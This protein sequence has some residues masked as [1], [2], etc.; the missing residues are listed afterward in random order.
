MIIN[1]LKKVSFIGFY[2]S[3][4]ILFSCQGNT[5]KPHDITFTDDLGREI[6]IQSH[7]P[8]RFMAISPSLTEMLYLIGHDSEIVGRTQNCNY[9]PEVLKKPVIH[10]YPMDYEGLISL[11]PDLVFAKEGIISLEQAAKIEEMGIPVFFQQYYKS[12]D[13]FEGIE[14]LGKVLGREMKARMISDSLR[15]RK[16]DLESVNVNLHRPRVL[17]IISSDK[18][19]A[20]GKNSFASDIL[21]LAG[22]INAIDT[23]LNN[24]FPQL[25]LEYILY[26]NPDVIIGGHPADLNGS[27][28]NLYPELRKVNAYKNNR[29]YSIDEDILSRP[30]PRVIEGALQIK[31]ILHPDA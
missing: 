11:K 9:P 3:I 12:E 20:H 24:D 1:R 13:I 14:E 8:L 30:G 21:Y 10:N 31:K 26:L 29:I 2:I 27:F 22:G 23:V 28:F 19:F 7:K 6:K 18:I 25:T 17:M 15:K 4:V 16:F 5:Y